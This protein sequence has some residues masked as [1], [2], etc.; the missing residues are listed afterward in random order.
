MILNQGV[1]GGER[2]FPAVAVRSIREGGDASKFGTNYPALLGGRYS[3]MWWIY[4]GQEGVFAARGVH[5]H[6]IHVD[7][8][9]DMVLVR[10][11]SDPRAENLLIDPT[12]LPGFRAEAE[13]LKSSQN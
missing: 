6:T 13:Y 9:A 4:P 1:V 12:S 10:Y 3:S 11:A 7:P 2:L 8:S 5:G